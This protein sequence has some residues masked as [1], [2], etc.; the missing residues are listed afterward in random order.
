MRLSVS[1]LLLVLCVGF[2]SG[3]AAVVAGGAAAGGTYVYTEGR[4]QRDYEA[5]LDP[6][7]YASL[8]AVS[9]MNMEIM[10]KE[11]SVTEAS[12]RA[13]D[14]DTKVWIDLD[15][16]DQDTTQISVRYGLTGDETASK[17]IHQAIAENM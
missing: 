12:I 15:S 7:Y 13:K 17:S 3:C 16:V 6:A 2:I 4:L 9:E 5:S 10:E 11:K 14:G 1:L 8:D